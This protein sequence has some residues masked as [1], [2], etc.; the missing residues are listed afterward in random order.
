MPA[1]VGRELLLRQTPL[2]PGKWLAAII[3]LSCL[4]ISACYE[5]LEWR[6]AG[7]AF[8]GTQGDPWDT[9]G[10]MAAALVGACVALL[11]LSRTH[12]RLLVA[13]Q[14]VKE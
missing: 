2:K 5:L 6:V 12:D 7:D 4:G 8:L 11:L 1:L 14:F 3:I 10:D 13:N 9:Q